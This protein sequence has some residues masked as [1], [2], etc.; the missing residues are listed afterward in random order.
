MVEEG[1][2]DGERESWEMEKVIDVFIT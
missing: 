2:M 1:E